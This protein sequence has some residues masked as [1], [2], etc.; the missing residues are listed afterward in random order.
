MKNKK[1]DALK[2]ELLKSFHQ[3]FAENQNH[4]QKL[5]FQILT[6]LVTVIFGYSFVFT[7]GWELTNS[8]INQDLFLLSF[9]FLVSV[10]VINLSLI[11]LSNMAFGYRRDQFV[12]SNIRKQSGLICNKDSNKDIFPLSYDPAWS[13]KQKQKG[14]TKILHKM[15]PICLFTYGF[16]VKLVKFLSWM[17]NFHSY[18]LFMLSLIQFL[19]FLSYILNPYNNI[20]LF[21]KSLELDWCFTLTLI[22]WLLITSIVIR[23]QFI[24]RNKLIDLYEAKNK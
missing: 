4:H 2:N 1:K 15:N 6:V 12:V 22:S 19:I 13:F 7:S 16:W 20:S 24:F 14:F 11:L 21:D 5:F 3:Q 9:A 8:K 10:I 18:L 23:V 17:P